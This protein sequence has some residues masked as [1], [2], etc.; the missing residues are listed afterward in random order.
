MLMD[1]IVRWQLSNRLDGVFVDAG[2]FR[3]DPATVDVWVANHTSRY[4]GFLIWRL[5]HSLDSSGRLFTIM[6]TESISRHPVFRGAGAVGLKPGSR[7]SVRSMMRF[8]KNEPVAGDALVIFP[9]GKIFPGDKQ[10]PA[11]RSITRVGTM[12]EPPGRF[13]PC[14]IA[15][16]MLDRKKPAAFLRVASAIP[17]QDA[18]AVKRTEEAVAGA[19]RSLREDLALHGESLPLV[20]KGNRLN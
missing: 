8:V 18:A 4:D 19:A 17:A 3:P 7:S 6:L 12:T 20:W 13:I 9:Q 15:V 16:E 2:A 10:P 1:V 11:F 14:A 5:K